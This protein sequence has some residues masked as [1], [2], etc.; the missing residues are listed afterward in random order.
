MTSDK[1]ASEFW[2]TTFSEDMI[3]APRKNAVLPSRLMLGFCPSAEL[4][5]LPET[6]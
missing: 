4:D 6:R 1:V 3:L 5:R 2:L